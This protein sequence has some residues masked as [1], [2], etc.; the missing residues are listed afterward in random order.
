MIIYK[1]Y[2]GV[3]ASSNVVGSVVEVVM[4]TC[5]THFTYDTIASDDFIDIFIDILTFKLEEYHRSEL[6]LSRKT[7]ILVPVLVSIMLSQNFFRD[8][9]FIMCNLTY[10][11][12]TIP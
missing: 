1:Q 10:I 9:A 8:F 12:L 3:P 6:E 2:A 5:S 4:F 7:S 11:Y